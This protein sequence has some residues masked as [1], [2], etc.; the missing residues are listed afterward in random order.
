MLQAQNFSK[1]LNPI[2]KLYNRPMTILVIGE[3]S[4]FPFQID[5][6]EHTLIVFAKNFFKSFPS[7]PYIYLKKDVNLSD[8]KAL[9]SLEHFDLIIALHPFQNKPKWKDMI[10]ELFKLGDHLVVLGSSLEQAKKNKQQIAF[11]ITHYLTNLGLTIPLIWEKKDPLLWY[12]FKPPS[13]NPEIYQKEIREKGIS[14]FTFQKY[15]GAFPSKTSIKEKKGEL[16]FWVRPFTRFIRMV[17]NP[18]EKEEGD[19][20]QLIYTGTV[21]N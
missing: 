3:D 1:A 20:F 11:K 4:V 2:F 8:L 6:H 21:L 10:D 5:N 9:N 12:C 15:L 7:F 16:P 18:Q 13:V 19:S 17:S 14:L